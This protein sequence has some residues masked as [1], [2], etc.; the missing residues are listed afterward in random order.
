MMTTQ[1]FLRFR[2]ITV[3]TSRAALNQWDT[4]QCLRWLAAN[5]VNGEWHCDLA[6][7][8]LAPYP[9]SADQLRDEIALQCEVA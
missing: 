3:P 5:D 7:W 9:F 8:G 6:S 2:N 4:L 1:D